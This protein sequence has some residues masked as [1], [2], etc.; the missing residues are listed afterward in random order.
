M[1]KCCCCSVK[2]GAVLLGLLNFLLPVL[3][4]IPLAGYLAHTD[5]PGLNFIQE[6]Y[7][8]LHKVVSDSL[9][10]HDWTEDKYLDIMRQLEEIFPTLVLSCTIYAGVTALFSFLMVLGVR[11]ETRC[12]MVPFLV[13]S[14]IDIILAGAAGVVVVVALFTLNTIPG[15]VS[16]VVYI[17]VAVVSL[18]SW[19]VILAAYKQVAN[20]EYIYSPV[21]AAVKPAYQPEYYPS[22]PQHFVMEEY[23]DLREQ[24]SH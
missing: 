10:S 21:S 12:L 1:R 8:V 14:M 22:A 16:L 4:S 19:A 17:M 6:N 24:K 23:R 3:V 5:V 13:L 20:E 9:K 15:A 11:C 2:T 7:M 18:Y